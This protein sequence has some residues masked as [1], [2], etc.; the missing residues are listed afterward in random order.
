MKIKLLTFAML[1]HTLG[2]G[3]KEIELP[4][5]AST[6]AVWSYIS[7]HNDITHLLPTIRIAVNRKMIVRDIMLYDGDEVALMPPMAGG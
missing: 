7:R 4:H 1:K 6:D 3:E 2:W 5:G